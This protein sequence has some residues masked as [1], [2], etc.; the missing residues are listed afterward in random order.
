MKEKY[1]RWK[2]GD[3][4][5]FIDPEGYKAYIADRKQAFEAELA[6]QEAGKM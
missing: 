1:A 5:A 4:N 2:Q 3:R 6:R